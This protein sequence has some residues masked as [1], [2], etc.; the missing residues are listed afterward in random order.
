MNIDSEDYII[1]ISIDIRNTDS[2]NSSLTYGE[3]YSKD[4]IKILFDNILLKFF[5]NDYNECRFIDIG[6]GCGRLIID[7]IENTNIFCTGVEIIEHRFSKSLN[8]IEDL[9]DDSI[10]RIEFINNNFKNIYFGNYNILYCCNL[11][12]SK[13]DNDILRKKLIKEFKGFA[14]LFHFDYKLKIYFYSKHS[15]KA[16][17]NNDVELYFYIFS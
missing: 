4:F 3:I 5:E 17:W 13:E 10:N 2:Y 11:V 9:E 7:I 8:L 14:F 15:V 1:D 12:F 6:S 16:S